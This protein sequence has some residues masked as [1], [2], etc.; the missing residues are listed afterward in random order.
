MLWAVFFGKMIGMERRRPDEGLAL[1][2]LGSGEAL[3]RDN[4]ST[5]PELEDF[6]LEWFRVTW[7]VVVAV[8]VVVAERALYDGEDFFCSCAEV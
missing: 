5:E 2:E 3:D 8:V 1:P 4:D 6:L 7:G